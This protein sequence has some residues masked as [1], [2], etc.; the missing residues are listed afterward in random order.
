MFV[1]KVGCVC[2]AEG[3]DSFSQ[4]VGQQLSLELA[5]AAGHTTSS[6]GNLQ[7]KYKYKYRF[8]L[9]LRIRILQLTN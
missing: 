3:W 1:E 7:Y 4:E 8:E 5:P 2:A 9:D 6:A